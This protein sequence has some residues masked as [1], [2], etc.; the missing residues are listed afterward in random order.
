[1][2][3]TNII[4]KHYQ[5]AFRA[6]LNGRPRI[7]IMSDNTKFLVTHPFYF[8]NERV[9]GRCYTYHSLD[10]N[11]DTNNE[12]EIWIEDS[13]VFCMES[14]WDDFRAAFLTLP[15]TLGIETTINIDTTKLFVTRI[16]LEEF[17]PENLEGNI[18]LNDFFKPSQPRGH[19][20]SQVCGYVKFDEQNVFSISKVD[21]QFNRAEKID[22]PWEYRG[23][24]GKI[25]EKY[26][27][28]KFY[29]HELVVHKKSNIK[30]KGT[31]F[32]CCKKGIFLV[33]LPQT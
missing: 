11:Y 19:T 7:M 1:M 24:N 22:I 28:G 29:E 5:I 6:D 2:D 26:R 25:T 23:Y 8:D 33:L 18:T 9:Y 10:A 3:T 17:K 21:W 15:K 16:S 12:I 13:G 20:P 14:N 27:S 4:E 31:V 32:S 30:D